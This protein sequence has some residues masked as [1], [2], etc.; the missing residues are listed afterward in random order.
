MGVL[1]TC[2]VV[3][4]C[5]SSILVELTTVNKCSYLFSFVSFSLELDCGLLKVGTLSH[6]LGTMY[7]VSVHGKERNSIFS[8]SLF[9]LF[10]C[11]RQGLATSS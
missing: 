3:L 6:I 8:K 1:P 2:P 10:E 7:R 9:C 4:P 5:L 11:M